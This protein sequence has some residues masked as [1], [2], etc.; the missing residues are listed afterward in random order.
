MRASADLERLYDEHAQAQF[1]FLL[2]FIRDETDNGQFVFYSIGWNEKD[3]GGQIALTENGS[4]DTPRGD[5]V[6]RY[7]AK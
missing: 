6:W 1:A 7:P 2:N 3:D 4:V 5:W